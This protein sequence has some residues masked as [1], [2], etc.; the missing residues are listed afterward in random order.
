MGIATFVM[1]TELGCPWV[2]DA[3]FAKVAIMPNYCWWWKPEHRD[4]TG[5][6]RFRQQDAGQWSFLWFVGPYDTSKWDRSHICEIGKDCVNYEHMILEDH[7]CNI[8][9]GPFRGPDRCQR[10]RRW[11][12]R[13]GDL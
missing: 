9:R 6:P 5:R 4:R 13:P 1:N 12:K 8:R 10:V 7:G 2:E 3:F 11:H